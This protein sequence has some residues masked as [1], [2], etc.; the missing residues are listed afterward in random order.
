MRKS[1]V[2]AKDLR[3]G[4]ECSKVSFSFKAPGTGLPPKHINRFIGRL[5]TK[6]AFM[7]S[8]VDDSYFQ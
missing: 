5:L 6:D 2:F 4:S 3:A 8:E 7:D 1:I